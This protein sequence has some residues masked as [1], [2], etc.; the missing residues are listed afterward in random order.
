MGCA[1]LARRQA[2]RVNHHQ[3]D[4]CA[5]RARPKIRRFTAAR[6]SPPAPIPSRS[7]IA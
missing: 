7:F 6:V 4:G 1:V 2:D 3:V 5:Q